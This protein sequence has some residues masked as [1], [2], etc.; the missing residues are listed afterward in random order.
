MS[1]TR[2]AMVAGY[3]YPASS[4]KLSDEIETLLS[5]SNPRINLHNIT[6]IIVPHAGYI[7]SGRTAAFAYNLLKGKTIDKVIIISPS[8]R[9]YFPGIC[10]FDGNSYETPLGIVEIDIELTDKIINENRIIYKGIEGHREEHAIEVQIPFLQK[11]LTEFKI[12]PIVM[13]DQGTLFIDELA[14]RI[15]QVADEKTLIVASSDLSHY[16]SKQEA[17]QLDS[18]IE[19]DINE[20]NYEK[21]RQDLD[22]KNCE[23]CGGGPIVAMMKAASLMN[24]KNAKVLNRSN[25]G[26]TTGDYSGV[27]GYLS[28]A[29]Y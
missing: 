7:Y 9:E 24:K 8:H 1:K 21:L 22:Y 5:I 6:G 11:V 10:I 26:D 14:N 16:Y 18:V 28:A 12:I 25:S 13:G 29:V 19:N 4:R 27:V 2:K 17:D 15:H 3:F 23:A 20:F